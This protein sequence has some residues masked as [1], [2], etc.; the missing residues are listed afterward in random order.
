MTW[1]RK[2]LLIDEPLSKEEQEALNREL[3]ELRIHIK[4]MDAG[5]RKRNPLTL[6]EA[7]EMNAISNKEYDLYKLRWENQ[8]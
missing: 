6:I 3:H 1:W 4:E 8:I 5:V 2:L 7:L